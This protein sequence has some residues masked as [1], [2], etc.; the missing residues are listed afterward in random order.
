MFSLQLVGKINRRA[1]EPNPVEDNAATAEAM[2]KE[3]GKQSLRL[4]FLSPEK[5]LVTVLTH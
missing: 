5:R 1:E 4:P 3:R 2:L